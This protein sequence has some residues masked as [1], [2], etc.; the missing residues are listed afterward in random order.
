M[1]RSSGSF[2]T[3]H[4]EGALLPPDL[5]SR[6]QSGDGTLPGLTPEAYHLPGT[7]RLNEAASRAWNALL[8]AWETFAEARERLPEDEP[9]TTLTRERWLLPLFQELGYGRLQTQTAREVGGKSYALSHAYGHA[10]LHLVGCKVHLDTR[11]RGVAGA[12]TGSPHSLLQEFLNRSEESRWGIVSNGLRL[13]ILRDNLALTR[14][15][16]LEFD[17]HS[18]MDG[19]TYSDFVLLFLILHQSRLESERPEECLLEQWSEEAA[20]TGTRVLED[21]SHGVKGAIDALGHGFLA[22]PANESLRQALKSGELSAQD[23]YRQL[24]RLVYRLLFLF[25]AE[26]RDALHPPGTPDRARER[27]YH[28]SARRLRQVADEL[29]GGRHVDAFDTLKVVFRSLGDRGE[30]ALGLP[31]LGSF[32]FSDAATENLMAASLPNAY[33]YRSVRALAYAE[34]DRVRRQ[35]DYKN[36]GSEELGGVYESLL[37]LHPEIDSTARTFKLATAAGNERKTTGSYYTPSSLISLLLDSALDPVLND[38][39]AGKTAEEADAAILDMKVVDPACG[40]G[41]F[42]IAAAQRMAKRLA[43]VRTGDEEPS[44]VEIRRAL[45]DVA[46]RCLYGVDVN[47]MSAEL[48]KVALWMEALEPG[49]PLSFLEHRIQVGNSLI[50]ATRD[51]IVGGIP[52]DAYKPIEGDERNYATEVKRRNREERGGQSGLFDSRPSIDSSLTQAFAELEHMPADTS[53]QVRAKEEAHAALLG[54]RM[55]QREKLLADAW[56]ASFVWPLNRDAP[57][58]L[59][60]AVLRSI[61]DGRE[62][63]TERQHQIE[64]LAIRYAFFHWHVAFP[65]V[66]PA[67][68]EGGF[69]VVLGNPPWEKVKLQ[70]QEWFASRDP[71]IAEAPN[72][73]ARQ[74]LVAALEQNDAE[75]YRAFLSDRRQA[76]G[77][78]HYARISGRYPL[79]GRGDI[80]TYPLFAELG[81]DLLAPRGRSGMIVPSGIATEATTQHFFR[82]LVETNSLA[83]L[84]DFE[85]RNKIFPGIDSRIKFCLLSLTGSSL[86]VEEAMFAF[87]LLDPANLRDPEKRFTLTPQ[88]I[89]LLNPNTKTLPI[90][91]THRDAE[92]TKGIYRRVPVLVNETTGENQWG[93]SFQRM[94]DM[95]IDSGLFRTREQLETD[96]LQLQGNSF[97]AEGTQFVPLYEAKMFHQFD[98]RYATYTAEGTAQE[99]TLEQRQDPEFAPMPRYW[100]DSRHVNERLSNNS[101]ESGHTDWLLA[102]RRIARNTDE[103]TCMCAVLP[104]VAAGHNAALIH[105]DSRLSPNAPA[106][107][108]VLNSFVLDFV[109]RQKV[110]GTTLNFFYIRQFPVLTPS[111]FPG[112]VL[113]QVLAH[114]AELSYTARDLDAAAKGNGWSRGPCPWDEERRFRIRTELDAIFFHLYGLERDDVE[115]VMESFPIVKRK[116]EARYGHYRTKDAILTAFDELAEPLQCA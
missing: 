22:H 44:P 100:V 13:R 59:T 14:Q 92:I 105:T 75:L 46:G 76:E 10:P 41:H 97:F 38:R 67:Q 12:A 21:L 91:R 86:R 7:M 72:A 85:N 30:S 26:D 15:A 79:A 84:Y 62:L 52:D 94:F 68:G 107:A 69:D 64:Q 98:H 109:A 89:E 54:D 65:E 102:V 50:G 63:S 27:Y 112:E 70:E 113:K 31:A 2:T 110:G 57:Q 106:L 6:I 90:F 20:R 55:F 48:C 9:G 104:R 25:V 81:R 74:R 99:V 53:E 47:E 34:V 37:E 35:V 51:L 116:D 32:L 80:N 8:G 58:P 78:S 60:S 114:A 108:A 39:T 19:E 111:G 88:D 66:F 115:Y 77:V 17:L 1:A 28:Y 45:R 33:L 82:D 101:G 103:R 23:Y 49:K 42:L 16:Y 3:I 24:L 96:G 5:L 36:L 71:E 40:S 11:T 56:T 95:A 93:I 4:S 73:A 43:A 87:F 29:R 61:T 83:S 18:M